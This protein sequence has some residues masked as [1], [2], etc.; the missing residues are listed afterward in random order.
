M[1]P[2]A[3]TALSSG[4]EKPHT[5]FFMLLS[6]LQETT[7]W[8]G[9][10]LPSLLRSMLLLLSLFYSTKNKLLLHQAR[11]LKVYWLQQLAFALISKGKM[12]NLSKVKYWLNNKSTI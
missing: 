7:V 5:S 3:E 2:G 1:S 10:C 12:T 11:A 9:A 4:P 6:L 8:T